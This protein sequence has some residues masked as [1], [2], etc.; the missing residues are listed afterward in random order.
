[1]EHTSHPD[2]TL[3]TPFSASR[4]SQY[5]CGWRH[6]DMAMTVPSATRETTLGVTWFELVLFTVV[7]SRG[8]RHVCHFFVHK[9]W[10]GLVRGYE[11]LG[12]SLL[13]RDCPGTASH[14][15]P[16]MAFLLFLAFHG[17]SEADIG[18]A[19]G[20]KAILSSD[21]RAWRV[22]HSIGSPLP[23]WSLLLPIIWYFLEAN[24]D[25]ILFC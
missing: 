11:L 1:M 10:L 9:C 7:H 21:D 18:T 17:W 5:S 12:C 22:R 3:A 16:Q 23:V 6:G 14:A 8:A 19:I 4:I 25:A 2:P 15:Y 13:L 20:R 24:L